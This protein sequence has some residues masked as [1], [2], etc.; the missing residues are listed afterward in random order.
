MNNSKISIFSEA[1]EGLHDADVTPESTAKF[2]EDS[3][4]SLDVLLENRLLSYVTNKKLFTEKY[5]KGREPDTVISTPHPIGNLTLQ[6]GMVLDVLTKI[7][8]LELRHEV[9]KKYSE[10]S[11]IDIINGYLAVAGLPRFEIISLKSRANTITQEIRSNINELKHKLAT[12]LLQSGIPIEVIS[13][14]NQE[15]SGVARDNLLKYADSAVPTIVQSWNLVDAD[16]DDN[17]MLNALEKTHASG[18]AQGKTILEIYNDWQKIKKSKELK[19][20]D[21]TLRQ[22][23][24]SWKDKKGVTGIMTHLAKIPGVGVI[25]TWPDMLN[26]KKLEEAY[27]EF[28]NFIEAERYNGSVNSHIDFILRLC[29]PA[30]AHAHGIVLSDFDSSK[31][32]A[33]PQMR[34]LV[35]AVER[36]LT[37]K[38][39]S[40]VVIPQIIMPLCENDASIRG[41]TDLF[42]EFLASMGKS[43]DAIKNLPNDIKKQELEKINRLMFPDGNSLF[44]GGFYG[45]SDLTRD[46]GGQSIH[47]ISTSIKELRYAWQEFMKSHKDLLP[48]NINHI[49]IEFGKG[50]SPKRGGGFTLPY[51]PTVQGINFVTTDS[52]LMKLQLRLMGAQAPQIYPFESPVS[53]EFRQH[54]IDFHKM[55]LNEDD[56]LIIR[57]FDRL[58]DTPLLGAVSGTYSNNQGTRGKGGHPLY[59]EQ[60]AI[61]SAATTSMLGLLGYPSFP[62]PDVMQDMQQEY[63]LD[64]VLKNPADLHILMGDL[65]QIVCMDVKRAKLLGFN[66]ESI[67]ICCDYASALLGFIGKKIDVEAPLQMGDN[68]SDHVVTIVDTLA[69]KA[70][71]VGSPLAESVLL[72][73]KAQIP[74]ICQFRD[75]LTE[76]LEAAT[77]EK[78]VAGKLPDATLANIAFQNNLLANFQLPA[79]PANGY[80]AE[81]LNQDIFSER[82][83]W[84]E[85]CYDF[86]SGRQGVGGV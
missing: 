67:N 86:E 20:A 11:I 61:S 84:A 77:Q 42:R 66:Q 49:H 32:Q 14:E 3:A 78:L 7:L 29:S 83:I 33:I 73:F 44:Y 74:L 21:P 54:A 43:Y 53:D 35:Q 65:F 45:P 60:R 5:N 10:E 69:E 50:T 1:F 25:Q 46:M 22:P 51:P 28:K 75:N 39:K 38:T 40:T 12:Q 6:Q 52:N 37:E 48:Y 26:D 47:F 23:R 8:K 55:L 18:S 64:E 4:R 72:Q 34:F 41:T 57:E 81:L 58:K 62:A 30:F 59:K 63:N 80:R 9:Q 71:Q 31:K 79:L 56:G 13:P 27:G 15:K 2:N 85:K 24:L 82:R 36:F 68:Y 70:V 19:E 17:A 76:Q 16:G